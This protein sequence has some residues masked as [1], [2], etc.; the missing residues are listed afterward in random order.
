MGWGGQSQAAEDQPQLRPDAIG[1]R[2]R[3]RRPLWLHRG[4]GIVNG[5]KVG[6]EHDVPIA[7]AEIG[8]KVDHRQDMDEQPLA[9][10]TTCSP[11]NQRFP[12]L[13]QAGDGVGVVL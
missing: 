8:G 3:Q 6:L 4:G 11:G 12:V 1:S 2:R 10:R 5:V 7:A 9:L 13:H